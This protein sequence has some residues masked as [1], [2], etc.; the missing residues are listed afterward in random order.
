MMNIQPDV[1]IPKSILD[2][3]VAIQK[4]CPYIKKDAQAFNYKYVD[5]ET[6]F[7]TLNPL[8][9]K[10]GL[11]FVMEVRDV[12]TMSVPDIVTKVK[13]DKNNNPCGPALGTNV[14]EKVIFIAFLTMHIIDSNTGEF[15]SLMWAGS[16]ENSTD[17]GFGSALTYG[18]RY[19]HLKLHRIVTGDDDPDDITRK[20]ANDAKPKGTLDM[21]DKSLVDAKSKDDLK[22]LYHDLE[23]WQWDADQKKQIA[24]KFKIREAEIVKLF[25]EGK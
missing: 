1:R 23:A 22:K 15:F 4:E 10:H 21:V 12:K 9:A 19:F 2:K 20:R 16:G 18:E 17:K 7:D 24:Y 8:Y 11:S 6:L 3:L 13:T 5:P 25:H 14:G